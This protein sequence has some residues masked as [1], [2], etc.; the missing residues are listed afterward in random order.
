MNIIAIDDEIFALNLLLE[1]I[2]EVKPDANVKGFSDPDELIEYVKNNQVDI[3]CLDIQI[4]DITGIELAKTIKELQPRVNII[5]VTAY[6]EYVSDAMKMHASGYLRKPVVAEDIAREFQ[7]L[8]YAI[9]GEDTN[10][11]LKAKCFGSFELFYPNG[12]I[13]HFSRAK[14]KE[15]FAYLVC[16]N[17]SSSTINELGTILFEDEIYD[18][19]KKN[20]IQ[21]IISTMNKDLEAAGISDVVKK[22]YNSISINPKLI[23]CDYYH[24][25]GGEEVPEAVVQC[26]FLDQYSW[27]EY[28]N[29]FYFDE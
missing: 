22:L 23:D 28:F 18:D 12:E 1:A 26:G 24:Y 5:F 27:A 15:A 16:K 19:K 11:R 7:D 4:Y 29:D 17:G 25:L 13:F 10:Y 3:A 2:N 14:S 20:Y 8:R 9:S 21:K 6:G